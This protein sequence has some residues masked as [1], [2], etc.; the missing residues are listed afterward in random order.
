MVLRG[1]G[2][3]VVVGLGSG[4]ICGG[5]TFFSGVWFDVLIE[6]WLYLI[7]I[8]GLMHCAVWLFGVAS[9]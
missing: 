8:S 2:R 6:T 3:V 4:W 5:G 1:G 9:E 7:S